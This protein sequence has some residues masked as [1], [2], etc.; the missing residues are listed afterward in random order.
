MFLRRSRRVVGAVL[1]VGGV[2][3]GAEP[4]WA[5]ADLESTEPEYG[6]VVLAAPDRAVAR[7]DLPVAVQGAQVTLERSGRPLQVDRPVYA[8]PDHK[9]VAMPLP[10]LVA[11]SYV[12]TWFL[13]G[14]DGDVMG[15]ELPFTVAG[16]NAP[17][18]AGLPPPGSRRIAGKGAFAPLGR[19]QDAA[20][21]VGLGSL[22]VLV[23][24]V[25]FIALLWRP[26]AAVR[27]TSTLLWGALAVA[28]LGN[29]AAL[30]LKGAAVSGQPAI[31]LF[32][33]SA[34]TAVAGTHVGRVLTARLGF[35]ILAVPFLAYLS[36]APQRALRSDHWWLGSGTLALGALTTHG[37]LSHASNRGWLA[38]AMD[39]V[40][41]GAVAVWLG[42]LVMLAVVVLPRRRWS[43][44]SM[45]VPRWS[46]LAFRAMT[47]AV[48]AGALLLLLLS[49][50]W[51]ALAG[52][53]YGRFLFVKLA[54]VAGLLSAASRARD[55]VGRRLPTLGGG[56][57]PESHQ[58]VPLGTAAASAGPPGRTLTTPSV[59][60]A[61]LRP[62][63]SAV[64]AE[65]C[66]AAS[67]LAAAAALVGRAPPL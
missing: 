30:G 50:R 54:L 44:L 47:T 18:T 22:S 9:A 29:A 12:L 55:F 8:S 31:R 48:L 65:L 53:S 25:T 20:R 41:V 1:L 7:Y 64:T 57:E 13:F 4:A 11:G 42:G 15:A 40:H 10:K 26:G 52:S 38:A 66:I 21:L 61:A 63:V 67:I 45:I 17:A 5:H 49:P 27:R 23:G 28:F 51:T 37:M 62:F 39:V 36:V 19:A 58:A 33:P 32:S 6:A 43:E 60:V 3:S 2:V 24:G 56:A 16:A 46:R 59:D 34:W 14:S 35:L